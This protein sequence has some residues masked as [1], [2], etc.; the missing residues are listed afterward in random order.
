MGSYHWLS[1]A[2]PVRSPP[3]V[4]RTVGKNRCATRLLSTFPPIYRTAVRG[5]DTVPTPLSGPR[6]YIIAPCQR[7]VKGVY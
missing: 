6:F 4:E 5:C 1:V 3:N 2:L 7:E